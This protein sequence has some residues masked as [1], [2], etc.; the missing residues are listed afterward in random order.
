M[1]LFGDAELR[2]IAERALKEAKGDQAE[3]LVIARTGSLTRYANAAIH[4]NVTSREA[5]LRV[6]VVIGHKQAT[7][8]TNRLDDDGIRRAA[9]AA[10]DLARRAPEDPKFGGLPQPRPIRPAPS[11]YVQRTAE[12]TPLDRA[13]ATKHICDA[14]LAAKLIAAGFVATNVQEVAIAN[15]LGVWAYAPQTHAEMQVAAIGDEGSAYAQRVSI[16]FGAL[17]IEG[18]TREAVDKAAR[19]QR[20][21]DSESGSPEVVLEP[22]AVRDMVGF[23]GGHFTGLA[24]EEGRSFV[25]GKL[26]QA[27]TGPVTLVD[28]PFDPLGMPRPFDF[29]GQPSERVTLIEKGVAR[30]IVYDSNTANRA[31]ARNTGHALPNNPFAPAMPMHARLEPGDKTREELIRGV[32]R[33]VLVTRFW[34]TRWVHQL[35]TIVTGMTRDGTFAIEDGEIAYPV[36]NLR[37][38][39]SYHEALQ[40][41]LGIGADLRLLVAGE[42]FGLTTSSQRVPALR[43]ASFNFTGATRY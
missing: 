32:K 29:E 5:E 9:T 10:A 24:V 16:D 1:T 37:F 23:L 40:G 7:A 20:P 26:G 30:A 15:S 34:Y 38:T 17:D 41:V 27:V 14:A 12:A 4:Q 19:A 31:G 18:G 11:A 25:A 28:D 36:K 39:Q 22:Y 43:L 8:T 42:Q 3:A 21:R 6:R 33:G 2:R 35:R 13:R